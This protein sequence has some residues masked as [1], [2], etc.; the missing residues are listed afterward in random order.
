MRIAGKHYRTI[1]LKAGNPKI[2]QIIDQRCLPHKFVLEDIDS[3][4]AM[5]AAIREMHLRGAPLIGAAGA[6][7]VYLACLQAQD[8]KA[9]SEYI[10]KACQFLIAARPTA[11]NLQWSVNKVQA[12]LNS[13]NS[14]PEKT[15]L[16]LKMV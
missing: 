9:S 15:A 2:I 7:G 13:A 10:E 16:A 8:D 12:A 1:W 3:H 14:L 11:V 5:E 4:I 6:Y